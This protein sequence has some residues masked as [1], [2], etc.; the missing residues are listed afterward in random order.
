LFLHLGVLLGQAFSQQLLF[1]GGE[2][3]FGQQIR[4]SLPGAYELLLQTP[5]GNGLV[6][7]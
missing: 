7:T 5:S 1:F 3:T 4:P 6:V 2:G